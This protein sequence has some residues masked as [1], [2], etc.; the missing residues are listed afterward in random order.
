[1]KGATV[2]RPNVLLSF[3]ALLAL[4]LLAPSCSNNP[5]D[6]SQSGTSSAVGTVD[7]D[8]D[9]DFLLG[10]VNIG[11]ALG[12][13][14][15]WASNLTVETDAVSFDAVTRNVSRTDI[16]GPLHFVITEIRP[17]VVEASNP[18]F[19][20]PDGPVYDFSDDVGEDGVLSAGEASA[21]VTMVFAMP[22][23][24]SFSVGFR[25]EVGDS[26]EDGFVSGIVFDDRNQNGE[27]EPNIE[28]GIPGIVVDLIP[29]VNRV[30]Y[31]TQTNRLGAYVFEGLDSDVY[32][33]RAHPGPHMHPTTPNPLIVTLVRRPDGTVT[34]LEG[35]DFGFAV[36]SPPPEPFPIFGPVD[37]GPGSH[38]GTELDTIFTVP[39]FFVP[40]DLFLRVDPP[41]IMGPFPID[42][43]EAMV[44]INGSR[45]WEFVCPPD[46]ICTPADR[47]L[48]D[49]S[50]LGRENTI[51][52]RVLGDE[53]S[54]L[55]FSIEAVT[56]LPAPE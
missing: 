53:R 52:I 37:V 3:L 55:M 7:P 11:S 38:A 9:P 2:R 44:D 14:E 34:S 30:L 43:D 25:V 17:D 24:M 27:Y 18:D 16:A 6:T 20:G 46:T 22:E 29:S 47:V 54:F 23:A 41:P 31:R 4:V 10:A 12:R 49:Q 48:L 28:P 1:M 56:I 42:I 39:D 36:P 40:V 26:V 32:T 13:V 45:V 8:G 50:Q 33:A 51:R 15:V 19:L 5:T 21:P 35:V